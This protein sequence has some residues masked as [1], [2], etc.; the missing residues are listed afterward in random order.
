MK[1]IKEFIELFKR[2]DY[3]LRDLF[4]KLDWNSFK[5]LF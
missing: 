4:N 2:G 1:M 5:L 3:N